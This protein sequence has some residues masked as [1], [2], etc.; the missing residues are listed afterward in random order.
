MPRKIF[1]ALLSTVL[2]FVPFVIFAQNQIDAPPTL[3][4][5]AARELEQVITESATLNDRLTAI[6]I[7]ARAANLLWLQDAR[8]ARAMFRELWRQAGAESDASFD[9]EAART[10]IL[11]NL[12]PR[13]ANLA[14]NLLNEVTENQRS[15]EASLQSQLTGNDPGLRRLTTLSTSLIEA[16][17]VRAAALLERALAVSVSPPTTVALLRLREQN[18]TIS[19]YVAARTIENLKT[20]PTVI[21]LTGIYL[22]L[23]YVFP[24]QMNSNALTV[25]PNESL[26]AQYFFAAY[27][28]LRRSLE[29]TAASL[30]ENRYTPA[31]IR[32][33]TMTQAQIAV[34]LST[35]APRYAPELMPDLSPLAARFGAN[36]PANLGQF[37]S[38]MVARLQREAQTGTGDA[39]N[40]DN[41]ETA[42]T[43]ALSRGDVDEAKRAVERVRDETIRNAL[44]RLIANVEPRILLARGDL[45][46]ALVAVR[47]IEDVN[48]RAT[49][50]AELARAARDK[51]ERDF[52]AMILGEAR[53]ALASGEANG[54]RARALL[55]LSA[56]AARISISDAVELLQT[57]VSVVNSLREPTREA[58]TSNDMLAQFNDPRSLI[59]SSELR[60]AFISVAT[61][62]FDNAI[63]AANQLQ[64]KPLQLV[65]RLAACEPLLN[66]TD[67]VPRRPT[68]PRTRSVP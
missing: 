19:D 66:A 15:E 33:R 23:E 56:E 12:F 54:L 9:R 44:S 45:A 64:F 48:A 8:R 43:V 29:E 13:D 36:V 28:I 10:E 57:T 49:L 24:S 41:P 60:Q 3:E 51:G 63:A 62:D 17:A 46:D 31:D 26:R 52:A 55:A 61:A 32:L 40:S 42:V 22:M 11:R 2:L 18:P 14:N 27:D 34:I 58:T 35:L 30:S 53:Q 50:Y 7:R 65:A 21:G 1:C 59:N 47:R 68:A 20:R 39:A 38:F 67:R 5:R 37:L 4:Q 6:K 25:Q 16:D